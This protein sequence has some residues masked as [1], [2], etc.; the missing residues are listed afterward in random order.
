MTEA[1]L[2]EIE[3]HVREKGSEIIVKKGATYY[4]VAMMLA[5]IVTA[6]LENNDLAL[7]LSAPLHG[8]Y[9]IKDEIYLAPWPSSTD[10]GSATYWNC[11]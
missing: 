9:G 2:D 5:K 7:P 8:E 3:A 11:R 4:G 6:I 10:K 1:A